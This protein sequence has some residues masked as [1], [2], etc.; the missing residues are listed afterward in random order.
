MKELLVAKGRRVQRFDLAAG[1]LGDAALTKAMVGSS[2]NLV[3]LLL[4]R[5]GKL[6]APTLRVGDRLLVGYNREMLESVFGEAG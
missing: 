4:G 5:S 1:P 6:R 2:T 3:D